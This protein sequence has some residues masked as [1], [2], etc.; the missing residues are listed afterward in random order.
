MTFSKEDFQPE[1]FSFRLRHPEHDNLTEPVLAQW[2]HEQE[3]FVAVIDLGDPVHFG[4]CRNKSSIFQVIINWKSSS[5]TTVSALRSEDTLQTVRSPSD[6]LLS[7]PPI[8]NCTIAL[9]ASS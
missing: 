5:A 7:I 4:L 9:L 1:F 2:D 8:L 6:I 3:V